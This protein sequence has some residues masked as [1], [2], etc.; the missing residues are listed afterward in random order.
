[1]GVSRRRIV[2]G[3]GKRV[4]SEEDCAENTL[5]IMNPSVSSY[6][7]KQSDSPTRSP[8]RAVNNTS[9]S[10]GE[11]D[12]RDNNNPTE[13]SVE[14]L[15]TDAKKPSTKRKTG[16]FWNSDEVMMFYEGLKEVS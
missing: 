15:A 7:Q 4:P 11:D 9:E 6:R 5:R 3:S 13:T 16:T 8:N 12:S 14:N 1:M 2:F 10:G